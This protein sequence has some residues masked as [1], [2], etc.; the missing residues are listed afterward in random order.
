[1]LSVLP[2]HGRRR[3]RGRGY[4]PPAFPSA[5][6]RFTIEGMRQLV[7]DHRALFD[8]LT[9]LGTPGLGVMGTS[10]GGYG[11]ALLATLEARLRAGV[12]FIPLSAI[13]AYA[14]ASGRF[15]GN[16]QEQLA[17]LHA[18]QAAHYPISPLARPPL[19]RGNQVVVIHGQADVITGREHSD[20]L[21]KH[22]DAEV[23]HFLGGH[24]LHFGRGRALEAMWRLL[25]REGFLATKDHR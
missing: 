15:I 21:V 4:L 25:A 5:D 6:P 8:Y 22:F 12:F 7:F 16:A 2:F 17:Q 3:A 10:L 11:A 19:I 23:H 13:E 14:Y 18:M 9:R 1:V 20:P 24:V